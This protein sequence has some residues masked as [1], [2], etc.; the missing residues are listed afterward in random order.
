MDLT[1]AQKHAV[2]LVKGNLQLIACAG[3]GKTEVVARRIA[4]LLVPKVGGGGGL[5]PR[6]IVSFTFTEKAAAELKERVTSRAG[7]RVPNLVGLA[8]MYVGTVHGFCLDLLK[9]EVPKFLKYEILN[10]VQ[11][12]LFISRNSKKCGLSGA[13]T[14]TGVALHRYRDARVYAEAMSVLRESQLVPKRLTGNT[15][16][17]GLSLYRNAEGKALLRLFRDPRGGRPSATDR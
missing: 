12:T 8:D 16:F 4:N 9:T 13:Q 7:E 14:L 3:S 2:D 10:D 6:N 17:D 15:V 11:Q 5:S 1:S